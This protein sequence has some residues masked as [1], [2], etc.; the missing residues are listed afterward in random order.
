MM[1]LSSLYRR[2]ELVLTGP[3]NE[4]TR[5]NV[6]VELSSGIVYGPFY[7]ALL[8]IPVV[9]QRMGAAPDLL[10]LYNSQAYIGLFLAAFSVALIPRNRVVLFLAICWSI[11]RAAFL[12]IGFAETAMAILLL[13]TLFWLSDG[14]PGAAYTDLIRRAYPAD[15]R[16]RALSVVRM[17][18]VLAMIIFT[19]LAGLL[20]DKTGPQLVFPIAGILGIVSAWMF[21]R[22]RLDKATVAQRAERRPVTDLFQV[23]R[24]DRRYAIY[25]LAIVCFGLGGLVGVAFIPRVL[26]DRLHLSY[27][28]VSWLG[29]AQSV[30]WIVGLVIWGRLVDKRG[31]AWVMRVCFVLC[32][33]IPLSYIWADTGWMLVPAFVVS[34]FTFGGIDLAFTNS[35]IEL[36]PEGKVYE[37]AA[38][39]RTTIGLRGLVGPFLGVWLYNIGVPVEM[40]FV[41]GA[42]LF[43]VGAMLVSRKEFKVIRTP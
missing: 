1:G 22:I 35:S 20:L 40:V 2:F 36:A 14:F 15:V 42:S 6:R 10:A 33:I 3:L 25:L 31:A 5:H 30:S 32:A 13:S 4:Q 38:I 16:G 18:M 8:L 34:G 19:P 11:G 21:L 7:A 39:Q 24:T 29:F 37:Y 41:L 9:M 12:A 43:L 17:G 23:V 26:V 28:G 27:E